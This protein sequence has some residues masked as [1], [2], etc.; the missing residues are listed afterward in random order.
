MLLKCIRL[1]DYHPSMHVDP[2]PQSSKSTD[3]QSSKRTACPSCKM[4]QYFDP[5]VEEIEYLSKLK[6][7]L[8]R[9]NRKLHHNVMKTHARVTSERSQ[10][11]ISP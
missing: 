7:I 3:H 6:V 2:N 10:D 1:H 5:G 8:Q 11:V 4:R 9:G